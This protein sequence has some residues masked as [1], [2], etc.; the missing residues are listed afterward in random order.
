MRALREGEWVSDDITADAINCMRD[1]GREIA[2]R[3]KMKWWRD[4]Y[5]LGVDASRK[6]VDRWGSIGRRISE[7]AAKLKEETK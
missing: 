3:A 7:L 6:H 1:G 5:Q 4:D 2:E